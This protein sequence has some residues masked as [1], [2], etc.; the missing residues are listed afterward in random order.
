FDILIHILSMTVSGSVSFIAEME[1][2]IVDIITKARNAFNSR[3]TQSLEFRKSQIRKVYQMLEENEEAI[4]K[5]L[6]SDM[7]KP[8]FE[9]KLVETEYVKND[10]RGM[11]FNL[12]EYT[13]PKSVSKNLPLITDHA[14]VRPQPLGLVLIIGTWNYP[15]MVTL[16]PLVGAIA[17]GNVAIIKPSELNPC[18]AD[19]LAKLIP[20]Y[21]DNECYHVLNGGVEK[22][23][24]LL[25]HKFDYIFFTGSHSVGKIIYSAAAKHLTPVTLEM[26]GKSPVF[27]DEE[28]RDI[29]V[30]WRRILWGK[31]VNA[32]QTCVAPDYILCSVTI[33][34]KL[35]KLT[36]KILKK[37][38]G[39]DPKNSP[40]FA[41][42]INRRHF[43]RLQKL[44]L[45]TKGT[46]VYGGESDA[47]LLYLGPTIVIDVKLDDPLMEDEIFGPIL[48]IVTVEDEKE[49][50]SI[51]NRRPK[52]LS[53][54]VFSNRQE[55]INRFIEQTSSGSFCANDVV[56]HLS[57]DSLPFGGVG[58]SG[59]GHYHG[60]HTFDMFSHQKAVLVRNFFSFIEWV[61]SK[62]YPPY[63]E[64]HLRRLLRLLRKRNIPFMNA[65]SKNFDK[66]L[67]FLLGAMVYYF[68]TSYFIR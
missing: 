68:F 26:G 49:A 47:D 46:I 18:T 55:I 43:H 28:L 23:S 63:S 53:L 6:D 61:A 8:S 19:L 66:I 42:I 29:E 65:F 11:L 58:E 24:V 5:A 64:N 20:H 67:F 1:K 35:V 16:S 44:L 37:F 25:Q 14:T 36:G 56:V 12:D 39:D 27:V 38:F 2:Q 45:N 57:A 30:S 10:C 31:V 34:D 9:T 17:A 52:P 59:F 54:Y 41:R 51:I 33:R 22:T 48:P 62:R 60:K 13:R 21:L 3:K 40:D 15:V 50:I 32:G 4:V 7:K